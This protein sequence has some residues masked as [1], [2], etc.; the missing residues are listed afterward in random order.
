M[1]YTGFVHPFQMD[2]SS[3]QLFGVVAVEALNFG[4]TS[5]FQEGTDS[6]IHSFGKCW[7][8]VQPPRVVVSY[9]N[10]T[11]FARKT[12]CAGFTENHVI[13]GDTVSEFAINFFADWIS[14]TRR[15]T[16]RFRV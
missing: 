7:I 4:F 5:K 10:A 15:C 8:K 14:A 11:F 3:V 2:C 16:L 6:F 1:G 13:G 12:F 9:E